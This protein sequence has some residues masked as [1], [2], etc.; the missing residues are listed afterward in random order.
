[1]G[2]SAAVNHYPRHI[3]DWMVATAHLSE[4]E[5]CVYSR[6]I[7]AYYAR[8]QP[9]PLDLVACCRLVRAVSAPTR[10]AV[11]IVLPEFFTQ[12]ADGWHQKRC[13]EE[14]IAFRE[15]S[16]LAKR[17]INARWSKK[18]TERNTERITDEHTDV[19]PT[20]YYEPTYE[21]NTNHKP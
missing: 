20:S 17:A 3:G 13:D 19:L 4:V 11:A 1:M 6:L 10:K 12:Q 18:N 2:A 9:L 21:R 14:L 16:E 15:R 7:D 5:E 8:E